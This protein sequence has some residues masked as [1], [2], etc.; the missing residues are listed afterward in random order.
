MTRGGEGCGRD[1]DGGEGHGQDD[2][3]TRLR[4]EAGHQPGREGQVT[5]RRG[6]APRAREGRR[7]WRLAVGKGGRKIRV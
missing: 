5:H 7:G 2:G 3:G 1:D 4:E 6:G